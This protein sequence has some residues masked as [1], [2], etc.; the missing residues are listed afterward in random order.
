M[1]ALSKIFKYFICKP[2]DRI[3]FYSFIRA[4]ENTFSL[5]FNFFSF[6]NKSKNRVYFREH[7]YYNT[8]IN[9]RFFHKKQGL[10]AY[11]NGFGK[12]KKE[13]K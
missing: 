11:G 2:I 1:N 3:M 5:L 4:D 6:L 7:Y 12:R 8:E 9:W 13:L 10:Y